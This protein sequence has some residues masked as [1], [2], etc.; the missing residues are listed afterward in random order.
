MAC[1]LPCIVT[2][3]GGSA[4]AV[5]DQVVGLVVPPGSTEAVADAILSLATDPDKQAQMAGKT[6]E[7]VQQSFDI[8]QRMGEL[9]NV[10]TA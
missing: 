6:R 8:E 1:G 3:V 5:K 4:E 2:N 9:I 7:T 10:I